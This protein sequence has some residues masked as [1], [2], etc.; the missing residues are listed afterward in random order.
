MNDGMGCLSATVDRTGWDREGSGRMSSV[1]SQSSLARAS[2]GGAKRIRKGFLPQK[3]LA[4]GLVPAALLWLSLSECLAGDGAYAIV[5][6]LITNAV[7]PSIDNAGRWFGRRRTGAAFFPARGANS[8]LPVCRRT[9]PTAAKSFTPIHLRRDPGP[10][11]G[12]HD[13]GPAD[14]GRDYYLGLSDFGVNAGGE[15]VYVAP[16]TNN[17]QQVFSTVRGQVT[18]DP[19]DHYNPCIN[20]LDFIILAARWAG[21]CTAVIDA[22]AIDGAISDG[23]RPE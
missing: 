6:L 21:R 9:S 10:G 13:P 1:R 23:L 7:H 12:Q 18:F 3:G 8:R 2:A 17:N 16:D 11:F 5:Q 20:D 22:R 15:V 4:R 14:A 19:V